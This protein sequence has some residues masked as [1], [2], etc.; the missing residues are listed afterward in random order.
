MARKNIFWKKVWKIFGKFFK[1]FFWKKI[2]ILFFLNSSK[3]AIKNFDQFVPL[4]EN[5]SDRQMKLRGP[6][7]TETQ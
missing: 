2:K 4:I 5:M 3:Y 1:I 7:K 6:H